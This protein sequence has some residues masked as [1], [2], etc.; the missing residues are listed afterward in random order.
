MP[1]KQGLSRLFT[2]VEAAKVLGISYERVR[3][4]VDEG[5]LPVI[6]VPGIGRIVRRE[7]LERFQKAPRPTGRPPARRR[8]SH[9]AHLA[10]GSIPEL[11]ALVERRTGSP[12]TLS[13]YRSLVKARLLPRRR[14]FPRGEDGKRLCLAHQCRRLVAVMRLQKRSVKMYRDLAIALKVYRYRVPHDTLTRAMLSYLHGYWKARGSLTDDDLEQFIMNE[15]SDERAPRLP[16]RMD[17]RQREAA[18]RGLTKIGFGQTFTAQDMAATRDGVGLP[19][20]ILPDRDTSGEQPGLSW[21]DL[22]QGIQAIDDKIDRLVDQAIIGQQR[23]GHR[24]VILYKPFAT[25]E[26]LDKAWGIARPLLKHLTPLLWERLRGVSPRAHVFYVNASI[27]KMVTFCLVRLRE[28]G[29]AAFSPFGGEFAPFNALWQEACV[30]LM[31]TPPSEP[32]ASLIRQVM[33]SP[34]KTHDERRKVIGR[35]ESIAHSTSLSDGD[36]RVM[37]TMLNAVQ[38]PSKKQLKKML[39]TLEAWRVEANRLPN[40]QARVQ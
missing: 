12:T 31:V 1:E 33:V 15:S 17:R 3:I 19:K 38:H 36:Q 8:R 39:A 20:E 34:P 27:V 21:S 37:N 13:T 9:R 14:D 2:L 26:E 24:Q 18:Y 4:F 29:D 28:Q 6:E 32:M 5:R 16:Y 30:R 10:P 23:R 40:T 11:L 22:F 35:L 25:P 7:D